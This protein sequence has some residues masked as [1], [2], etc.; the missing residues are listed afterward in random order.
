MNLWPYPTIFVDTYKGTYALQSVEKIFIRSFKTADMTILKRDLENI[1]WS[2]SRGTDP[3]LAIEKFFAETNKVFD[4]HAPLKK[5]TK[6]GTQ[7]RSYTMDYE[8]HLKVNTQKRQT[9]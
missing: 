5:K 1:D 9:I 6:E 2:F 8:R 7:I 3:N 4:K